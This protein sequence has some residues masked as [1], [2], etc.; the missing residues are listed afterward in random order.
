MNRSMI[1][2]GSQTCARA[3][4]QPSHRVR[5]I[6]ALP[7]TICASFLLAAGVAASAEAQAAPDYGKLPLSFAANQGQHEPQ[8]RF[9]ARGRGY[10]LFLTDAGAV[11]GLN[12]SSV[13]SA[14]EVKADV[15]RMELDNAS[16]TLSVTGDEPL[17]G[18]ANYLIGDD[19][20][21]WHK[22]IPTFAKVRYAGVYPGIDLVYYGN[23]RRLE[24]DFVVAPGADAQAPRLHFTGA[25]NLA[26]D[27]LG[28]LTVSAQNGKI[29]FRRPDVYQLKDGK[30]QAVAG[31]FR[32]LPGNHL[33]FSI[34]A[35]DHSRSLVIDPIFYLSYSTYLGGSGT[36][37]GGDAAYGIAVDT[38]G[39]AY[40]AGTTFSSNFPV[41][42][43]IFPSFHNGS[44]NCPGDG[45]YNSE[46]FVTKFNP[47][48]NGVLWSTYF[49]GS[50]GDYATAIAL[51]TAGDAY[52]TGYTCS[53]N[54]PHYATAYQTT[55][56]G[57]PYHK[58][59]AFVMSINAAGNEML[60][61]TYLGGSGGD[62]GNGIV[63]DGGNHAYVVGTTNSSNFP[64]VGGWQTTNNNSAVYGASSAFLAEIDPWGE[65]PIFSTYFGPV[66]P[67]QYTWGDI[68]GTGIALDSSN[69][70]YITGNTN[71]S[72]LFT[73][74]GAFQTSIVGFPAAFVTKFEP[75]SVRCIVGIPCPRTRPVYSTFLG[76]G[77]GA[78]GTAIAV[79]AAGSA[80]VTGYAFG[81]FPLTAGAAETNYA[82]GVNGG[83]ATPNAFITKFD[84]TGA[85]LV[86]S[87]YL[88]GSGFAT[89][90]EEAVPPGD[91][92]N[93]IALDSAGNAY[94]TGVTYSHDFPTT[95]CAYQV[96]NKTQQG[97]VTAFFTELSA[98]GSN[99]VYSTYLGGSA[100]DVGTGIAL[101]GAGGL[102]L[103]GYTFSTNFPVHNAFQA[104]EKSPLGSN[105]YVTKFQRPSRSTVCLIL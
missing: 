38:S 66:S 27:S 20:S 72:A 1:P 70:V 57:A 77:F 89:M 55:N 68:Q 43:A 21:K 105:A 64:I 2:S 98:N 97:S 83:F 3:A 52:V 45:I 33:G 104:T 28:D 96:T 94:V 95:P 54:F 49:G 91:T 35:Y 7:L 13:N 69:N 19:P 36:G 18:K 51:D 62:R 30:R 24:Y 17:P 65:T 73:T 44:P 56:N 9:S 31:S 15:I 46:A 11:I 93:S 53:T 12:K 50:G 88:G 23:Q 32:L 29:V 42:N 84:P 40:V 71:S 100:D 39:D 67:T 5:R 41:A 102:Y 79:D 37:G 86:Y 99:F 103:T 90:N 34:G 22:D 87:T 81:D 14:S 63:V 78:A 10:S 26:I 92:A 60:Y 76:G 75:W 59:V 82:G 47:A 101:D 4:S 74:A 85:S 8:V 6:A 25:E 58:S 48:G 80:Y 16:P 61:S